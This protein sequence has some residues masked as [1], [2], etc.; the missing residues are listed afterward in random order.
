MIKLLNESLVVFVSLILIAHV[1][2][3]HEA[4]NTTTFGTITVDNTVPNTG[5]VHM[6]I[7]MNDYNKDNTEDGKFFLIF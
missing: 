2:A 4:N 3:T 5:Q 7:V 6:M 1:Q